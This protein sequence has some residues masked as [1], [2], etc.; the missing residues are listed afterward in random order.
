MV[1]S[2]DD[3][4][5]AF[6]GS[7]L[8]M[9]PEVIAAKE[10]DYRADIWSLGITAI[11]IA[12]KRLPHQDAGVFYS[13]HSRPLFYPANPSYFDARVICCMP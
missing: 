10:V 13:S 7:P 2:D 5:G 9:A 4:Q 3:D 8:W 12:E 1:S 6:A 11:E